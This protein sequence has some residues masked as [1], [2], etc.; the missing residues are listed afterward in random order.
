MLLPMRIAVFHSLPSGGARRAMVEML[1]QLLELGH[2]VE[3]YLTSSA[4]EELLPSTIPGIRSRVWRAD[5]WEGFGATGRVRRAAKVAS[6]MRA[7][8]SA[9][10]VQA[11]IARHIDAGGY[12]L[13]FVHHDRLLQAPALLGRLALPTV[14][15]CQEPMRAA[16][17]HELAPGSILERSTMH[18]PRAGLRDRDRASARAADSVLANSF[19]SRESIWR[20]Y[21]IDSTVVYLGVDAE[22][23]TPGDGEREPYVMSAGALHPQ[24]GHRD[25]I[26]ALATI[27]RD[28]RPALVV[29][30]DRGIP[31]EADHLRALADASDV[32][33]TIASRVSE[34]ELVGLYRRAML[35]LCL[36]HLEPFGLVALEAAACGTPSIGVREAGLRE[37][38]VEG[39]TGLLADSR[40]PEVLGN[41]VDGLLSDRSAWDDLAGS[42]VRTIRANWT[43][44]HT[45]LRLQ[46]HFVDLL[47]RR[48]S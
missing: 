34:Q 39:E 19:Y 47:S 4:D 5:S 41:M 27:P 1:K 17:E 29:V 11:E 23:F 18:A 10:Q 26:R 9:S 45:G 12:D 33:L 43:W 13:A 21:G 22:V 35:L 38:I 20:V 31:G 16:Y 32:E 3:M 2:E 25:A 8:R 46:Q 15:Y 36:Q 44:R 40:D 24:K 48:A 30:G 37:A 14:Y 6:F 28:R 7:V 42:S